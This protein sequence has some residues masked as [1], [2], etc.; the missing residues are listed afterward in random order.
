MSSIQVTLS[1]YNLCHSSSGP[2]SIPVRIAITSMLLRMATLLGLLSTNPIRI[3]Q[4]HSGQ[5]QMILS[6]KF[7]MFMDQARAGCTLLSQQ[8]STYW[9]T[10]L[11]PLLLQDFAIPRP[12]EHARLLRFSI[13]LAASKSSSSW[14]K[15]RMK[16]VG[17][18]FLKEGRIQASWDYRRARYVLKLCIHLYQCVP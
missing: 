12:L 2:L 14:P 6:A 16:L 11:M 7:Q 10:H 5:T 15:P 13:S 3:S 9:T 18:I 8:S 4:T 1:F 17:L